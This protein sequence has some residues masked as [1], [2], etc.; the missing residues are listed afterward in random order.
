MYRVPRNWPFRTATAIRSA[1]RFPKQTAGAGRLLAS[2]PPSATSFRQ[3]VNSRN[4]S[5]R[6]TFRRAISAPSGPGRSGARGSSAAAC[7][8]PPR[9]VPSPASGGRARPAPNPTSNESIALFRRPSA[10]PRSRET[11]RGRRRPAQFRRLAPDH[12]PKSVGARPIV[13]QIK[14]SDA[15]HTHSRR[16]VDLRLL[17]P[18]SHKAAAAVKAARPTVQDHSRDRQRAIRAT[19]VPTSAPT[20]PEKRTPNAMLNASCGSTGHPAKRAAVA[21]EE[22]PSAEGDWG[23]TESTD[24]TKRV[25]DVEALDR[26]GDR[27]LKVFEEMSAEKREPLDGFAGEQ[28][29]HPARQRA[30]DPVPIGR[31]SRQHGPFRLVRT[32]PTGWSAT[33][34]HAVCRANGVM[35][36]AEQRLH[37]REPGD[38]NVNGRVGQRPSLDVAGRHHTLATPS[39]PAVAMRRGAERIATPWTAPVWARNSASTEVVFACQ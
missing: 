9:P 20:R 5:R 37:S 34:S 16:A 30:P 1:S 22:H 35:I 21:P 32:A 6:K 36:V 19:N 11:R 31:S 23:G 27:G 39:A 24:R 14:P 7:P 8:A 38:V 17:P 33:V 10:P 4:R 13:K 28:P 26:P 12:L 29:S 18:G 2:S 3:S 15:I 25:R